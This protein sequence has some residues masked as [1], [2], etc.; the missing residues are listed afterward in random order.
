MVEDDLRHK[1][2]FS[3]SLHAANSTLWLFFISE[4]TFY[5]DRFEKMDKQ[6]GAELGQAQ[7]KL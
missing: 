4:W 3:G 2:T 7:V 6:V 1:T 5:L